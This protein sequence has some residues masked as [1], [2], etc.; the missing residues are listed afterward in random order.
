MV[1]G[2]EDVLDYLDVQ[3][4]LFREDFVATIREGIKAVRANPV[5]AR[6][7]KLRSG[8][9]KVY[10]GFHIKRIKFTRDGIHHVLA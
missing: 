3:F 6:Y 5:R 10:N 8:D 2:Y 1:T 7:G 4:R 9:C